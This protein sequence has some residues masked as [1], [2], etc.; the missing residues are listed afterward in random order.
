[1]LK[2]PYSVCIQKA[3]LVTEYMKSREGQ[4]G[5]MILRRA[6]ALAHILDHAEVIIHP[7]ELIVG[8]PASRRIAAMLHP[9]LSGLLLWPEIHELRT[10]PTNPL[11]ITDEEI[12]LL[13]REIFP[14]WSDKSIA[15]YSGRFCCPEQPMEM[16]MQIGY[17]ILTQFA[18]ISHITPKYEKVVKQGFLGIAQE[19]EAHIERIEEIEDSGSITPELAGQMHF[20]EAVRAVCLASVRF[21]ERYRAKALELAERANDPE[22]QQELHA[23]AK[24]LERVPARPARTF[25]EALQAIWLAHVIVHQE[26][27][28]HGISF[29][30]LD[31]ILYPYY[32]ADVEARR[33]DYGDAV[34]LVGC[35]MVKCAEILPLF[36]SIGT[37][38]FSG[39]SSAQGITLG[40]TDSEG[41]DATNELSYALLDSVDAV[42]LRQPNLHA[43]VHRKTPEEFL[44]KVADVIKKGGGMPGLFGDAGIIPGLSLQGNN[45]DDAWD[46]S[47]VGCVEPNVQGK[48]FSACGAAFVN[49][50]IALEMAVNNGKSLF[51]GSAFGPPTGDPIGFKSIEEVTEALREQIAALVRNAVAGNNAIELAHMDIYPTPLLSALVDGCMESGRDVT[52]GGALYNCTGMQ[53]V[54]VADVADSLAAIDALVF[55]PRKGGVTMQEMLGALTDNFAGHERL[56]QQIR[57]QVPKF[58]ND[59][60][61]ADAFAAKVASMYCKE[62]VKYRNPRG[63]SYVPGFWS[64]TTHNGFGSY[65]GALPNGRKAG[66][67]LTEGITPAAGMDRRGPT[68]AMKSVVSVDLERIGNGCTFN[69]KFSPSALAGEKGSRDLASLIRAYFDLGGMHVQFNVV[70]RE[71]LIDAKEHPEKYPGLLVRISGYSAY[72][73]DLTPSMQ[74]EIIERTEQTFGGSCCS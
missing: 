51:N 74:D 31:R 57:N 34:E 9:D 58:G 59:D 8:S 46:Y 36:N 35:M 50:A 22:R 60:E 53:G 45:G 10:R 54:G 38:F 3:R 52:A 24:T 48:T 29:G 56:L 33:L 42:R 68:A 63:G 37:K 17:Y 20:Y 47:I 69:Q 67:G 25:R 61:S 28:Q 14:F 12:Q 64:M 66:M 40:G 71:T 43:R 32:A 44:V 18:G 73:A 62:V 11:Q 21:A 39:L 65:V 13:E 23:V 30:R 41:N 70:D 19:A 16:F 72:F 2:T 49:L 55:K 1:M 26:N 27:F 4:V 5:P 15:A 7:D 6:G